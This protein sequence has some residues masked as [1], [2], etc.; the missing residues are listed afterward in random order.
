MATSYN[1]YKDPH[2]AG[3]PPATSPEIACRASARCRRWRTCPECAAIRQARI[4]DAADRIAQC[5][6]SLH[7]SRL[8]PHHQTPSAIPTVRARWRR[9]HP[10]AAG[11][12]TVEQGTHHHH[13]HLNVLH[14][15][16]VLQE[17][18]GASSW[19]ATDLKDHRRVAAYIAKREQAPDPGSYH[20]RAFG[21][22]GEPW[23]YLAQARSAP[24]LSAAALQFAIDPG[25]ASRA[26][27]D[28]HDSPR[29]AAPYS[30]ADYHAIAA[31]YLPDLID[32]S[33]AFNTSP[34]PI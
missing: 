22:F 32:L 10:Q 14:S 33:N 25:A 17:I 20:G 15:D 11:L 3:Q 24:A 29:L 28:Y 19:T 34:C 6:P 9:A 8:T 16:A 26:A 23:Y 1:V 4:A 21:T 7:W 12:W 31:R 18:E 30:R 13:L 27:L 2:H 5:F